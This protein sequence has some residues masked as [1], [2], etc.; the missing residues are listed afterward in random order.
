M[1]N[2]QRIKQKAY[3]DGFYAARGITEQAVKAASITCSIIGFGIGVVVGV[4]AVVVLQG[5]V[6]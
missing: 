6:I 1:N 4:A 2:E 5:M 3:R